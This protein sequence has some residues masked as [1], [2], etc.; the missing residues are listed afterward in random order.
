MQTALNYSIQAKLL[1]S[2]KAA[3]YPIVEIESSTY[4][5][6]RGLSMA[7]AALYDAC[8]FLDFSQMEQAV[9]PA[10][11]D[12][13]AVAHATALCLHFGFAT[14]VERKIEIEEHFADNPD[15]NVRSSTTPS[16][17]AL[18]SLDLDIDDLAG[19][20]GGGGR[21]KPQRGNSTLNADDLLNSVED[22]LADPSMHQKPAAS[23]SAPKQG[24][25]AAPAPAKPA[26]VEEEEEDF[27]PLE[28]LPAQPPPLSD[29]EGY[30]AY[31]QL[32]YSHQ[33]RENAILL[34]QM[35][36]E[37]AAKEGK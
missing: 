9:T 24:G 20:G 7:I 12:P 2:L 27:P 3:S 10:D 1:S 6:M 17:S 13:N 32:R 28:P 36:R 37:R 21:S 29:T 8:C 11:A 30:K 18:D 26:P 34:R 31:M 14:P 5:A 25:A 16:G 4:T 15:I 22:L 23:T 33:Q 19:G 35:K